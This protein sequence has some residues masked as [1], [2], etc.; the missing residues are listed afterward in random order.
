MGVKITYVS[1]LPGTSGKPAAEVASLDELEKIFIGVGEQVYQLDVTSEEATAFAKVVAKYLKAA[2]EAD[3][4]TDPKLWDREPGDGYRKTFGPGGPTT[5]LTPVP[6]SKH[7]MKDLAAKGAEYKF[8][9]DFGGFKAGANA[10]ESR[11][12]TKDFV[13]ALGFPEPE[14]APSI[15]TLIEA[16]DKAFEDGVLEKAN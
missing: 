12:G 8:T 14:R 4:E 2:E 1:D 13:V 10:P 15:D 16:I 6:Q 7:S 11:K 5:N 3:T 9:K